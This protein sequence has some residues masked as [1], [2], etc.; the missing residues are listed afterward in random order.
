VI[1][2][3]NG[4]K[5]NDMTKHDVRKVFERVLTWPSDLQDEAAEMLLAMEAREGEFYH[6]TAE[7]WAAIEQGMREAG[8]GEFASE[9][10]MEE[11]FRTWGK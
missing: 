2:Q 3:C 10:E 8:A 11:L 1:S 7:E 4:T 6:P 5:L 9:A